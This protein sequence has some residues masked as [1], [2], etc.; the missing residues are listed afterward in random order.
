MAGAEG[1]PGRF[2]GGAEMR[3]GQAGSGSAFQQRRS[4][5][6]TSVLLSSL[7]PQLLLGAVPRFSCPLCAPSCGPGCQLAES[8]GDSGFHCPF[9]TARGH[10]GASRGSSVSCA[11]AMS[12]GTL[13]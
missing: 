8:P 5:P 9:F 3:W 12:G 7:P 13:V 6:C 2:L 1:G 10:G 11:G 4:Q